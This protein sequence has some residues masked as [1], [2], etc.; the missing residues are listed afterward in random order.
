MKK[1]V[2]LLAESR[3][4]FAAELLETLNSAGIGVFRDPSAG[5]PGVYPPV[6]LLE[7]QQP[8]AVVFELPKPATSAKLRA[9]VERAHDRGRASAARQNA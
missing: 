8:V 6:G 3:S 9:V 5:G 7:L 4:D 1:H 2:I